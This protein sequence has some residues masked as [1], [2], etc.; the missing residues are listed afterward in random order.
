VIVHCSLQSWKPG[1]DP[2]Y[3]FLLLALAALTTAVIFGVQRFVGLFSKRDKI[4]QQGQSI[5]KGANQ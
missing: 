5:S 1:S 2:L 3:T 4:S